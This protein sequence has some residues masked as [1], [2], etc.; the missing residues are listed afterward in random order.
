MA[1]GPVWVPL[2]TKLYLALLTTKKCNRDPV[3]LEREVPP[4]HENK[5]SS[6][7]VTIKFP[8]AFIR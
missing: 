8:G 5:F 4:H 3:P 6:K 1:T 2:V 7:L